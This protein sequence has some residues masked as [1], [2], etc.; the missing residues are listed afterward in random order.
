[1]PYNAVN[2]SLISQPEKHLP[3]MLLLEKTVNAVSIPCFSL[4]RP[5]ILLAKKAAKAAAIQENA[6]CVTAK[7]TDILHSMNRFPDTTTT[8]D[9]AVVL[10]KLEKESPVSVNAKTATD[11]QKNAIIAKEKALI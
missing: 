1:M 2:N 5:A 9:L 3:L 4:A 10:L 6:V 7:A 8:K 11:V